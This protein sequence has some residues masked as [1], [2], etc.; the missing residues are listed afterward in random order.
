MCKVFIP[1]KG[2][3]FPLNGNKEDIMERIQVQ[4]EDPVFAPGVIKTAKV[5]I[6]VDPSGLSC[7]IEVFLGPNASIKTVT[8]GL[9]SFISTGLLQ[10]VNAA[11]TM[12]AVA[13]AS[14]H[15]YIDLYVGGMYLAGY[16]AT[17]DVIIP[18]GSIGPITWV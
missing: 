11:I 17:E 7:E 4:M 5:P 8:S 12:P 16:Q 1:E 13:G 14:Y 18:S 10:I 3:R 9:K 2:F 15:V 6:D